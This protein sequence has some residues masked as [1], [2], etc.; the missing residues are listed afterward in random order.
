MLD[1]VDI[2]DIFESVVHPL[3]EPASHGFDGILRIGSDFE[4]E[5]RIW[6]IFQSSN[7]RLPKSAEPKRKV[8]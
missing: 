8:P 2:L 3:G 7:D 4:R 1:H 6:A 5:V